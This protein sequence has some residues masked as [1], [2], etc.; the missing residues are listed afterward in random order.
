MSSPFPLLRLPRLVLCEVFKSLSIGEK[1]K[2]SLCSKKVSTQINNARLYSQKVIVDLD[3]DNQNIIIYSESNKD[4][5]EIV[6]YPD[7]G[8]SHNSN[9]RQFL[10]PRNAFLPVIQRILKMF[11]CKC[12][13]HISD[14]NDDSFQ[15]F[16]LQ[17]Q[18]K[19]L[20]VDLKRIK[21]QHLFLNQISTKFGLVEDLKITSVHDLD[22][23]P[24]FTSWPQKIEIMQSA[25]FTMKHMLACT[26]STIKLGWSNLEIKD[27]DVIL[28]K[29]KSGGFPNLERLTLHSQRFTNS[30]ITI[31]G[32]NLRELNEMIIQTDDGSKKATIRIRFGC[33]ELSVTPFE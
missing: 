13:A 22:F 9:T 7:S 20:I 27:L 19:N 15:L 10:I 26:C 1:I 4:K 6:T 25:W 14:Y 24:V 11:Q 18:F 29:W 30:G 2:L 23:S 8:I 21:D 16:D 12:S 17:S 3:I 5:F 31:L 28:R 32:R 33:V